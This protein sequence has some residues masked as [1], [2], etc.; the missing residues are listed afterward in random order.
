MDGLYLNHGYESNNKKLSVFIFFKLRVIGFQ[1]SFFSI[2]R[3]GACTI[4]TYKIELKIK[5]LVSC[6]DCKMQVGSLFLES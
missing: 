1:Q 6:A 3:S 2:S 4:S 5:N